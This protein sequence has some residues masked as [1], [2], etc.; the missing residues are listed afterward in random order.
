MLH[1]P[2]SISSARI[3]FAFI[4][5]CQIHLLHTSCLWVASVSLCHTI[6]KV[7]RKLHELLICQF[8][9]SCFTHFHVHWL[10][11]TQHHP[12]S[13]M[14]ISSHSVSLHHFILNKTSYASYA[15]E[16]FVCPH[17]LRFHNSLSNSPTSYFMPMGGRR[18]AVPQ[19]VKPLQT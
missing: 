16:H 9:L 8:P 15:T 13:V 3:N 6:F 12:A 18:I 14:M 4:I 19:F 11:R 2:P 1:M 10:E 17:Q 7:G 5:R